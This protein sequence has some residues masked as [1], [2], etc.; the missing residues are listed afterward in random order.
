[1]TLVF[2]SGLALAQADAEQPNPPRQSWSFSGCSDIYD[3]GQLQR[4]FQVLQGGLQHLSRAQHSFPHAH[5]SRWGR[6]CSEDQIR[7]LAAI[8]T[9]SPTPNPMRRAKS[10]SGPATPADNIPRPRGLSERS[11]RRGDARQGAA[12][13]G[14]ARQGAQVRARIFPWFILDGLPGLEYQEIGAD[15]IHG[16]MTRLYEARRFA[17]E[18]VLSRPQD[19]DCRSR[20]PMARSITRMARSR[21]WKITPRTVAAFLSWAAEPNL[22]ERK[23]I[24]LR[25]LIFLLV[26]AVLLYFVKKR[27]W[28]S[29]H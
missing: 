21:P 13:Y 14:V 6:A 4:G 15:V 11:G 28:A 2:S 24:G 19:R 10:S 23:R 3:K 25:V 9:R 8:P 20:S 12:G 17:V 5:G 29:A 18:L 27:I 16:I 26:F 1:V 7:T 22:P